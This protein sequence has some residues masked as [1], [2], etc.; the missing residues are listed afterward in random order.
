[1]SWEEFTEY[2]ENMGKRFQCRMANARLP[3]EQWEDCLA[4][5]AE[6]LDEESKRGV[7]PVN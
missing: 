5:K 7:L 6:I 4:I 2:F 3:Q 1:M